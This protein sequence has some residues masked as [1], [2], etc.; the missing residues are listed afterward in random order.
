MGRPRFTRAGRAYTAQTSRT[1]KDEQVKEPRSSKG[2][3]IGFHSMESLR[4]KS[5]LS[6]LELRAKQSEGRAF[7]MVE[8]GGPKKPD[9]DN[10]A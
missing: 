8:S 1:Y 5:P 6:I 4:L 2:R 3:G 9:L 7:L 10:L